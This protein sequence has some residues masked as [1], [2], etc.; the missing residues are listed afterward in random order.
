M[1][2]RYRIA[3][4]LLAVLALGVALWQNRGGYAL[5]PNLAAGF[6]VL[7]VALAYRR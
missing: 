1:R 2:A 4:L 3:A 7:L 6:A 5:F